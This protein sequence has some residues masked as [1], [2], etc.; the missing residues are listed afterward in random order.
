MN[1]VIVS[2]MYS[3]AELPTHSSSI[4]LAINF[5]ILLMITY[6]NVLQ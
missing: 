6:V 4:L 5:S 1:D 2:Y 3:H